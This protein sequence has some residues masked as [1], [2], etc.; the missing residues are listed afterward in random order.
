MNDLVIKSQVAASIIWD[1]EL[2]LK[3]AKEIMQKYVG[4]EFDEEQLP[5]AK[6]ELA[7]LRK[8]A[9]EINAQALSIDKELTAEVKQFR[10][11]VKDVIA[12]VDKGINYIDEQVKV[13][14]D[15][16]DKEKELEIKSLIEWE[17]VS[18]Y[19]PFDS[20]WLLKKYDM[21]TI[22]LELE[23]LIKDIEGSVATIKLLATS[24]KLDSDKYIDKLKSQ[25]LQAI[26]ERI[27]EDSQLVNKV[28]V[29]EEVVLPTNQEQIIVVRQ[30]KGSIAAL[31]ELKKYALKIGIEWSE[32]K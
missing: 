32:V 1:K 4:L 2:A 15:K 3:E 28:E 9:K 10:A 17:Y 5:E 12:E 21:E 27:V 29:V 30:L 24:H 6:K 13:F 19:Y 25:P 11:D 16:Q 20:K 8:V 14:L 18:E 23:A 7:T 31:T 22:K 26:L